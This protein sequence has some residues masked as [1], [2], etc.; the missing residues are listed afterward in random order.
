M[1]YEIFDSVIA[2]KHSGSSSCNQQLDQMVK[3]EIGQHMKYRSLGT[4]VKS[5]LKN[6]ILVE[7]LNCVCEFIFNTQLRLCQYEAFLG[8]PGLGRGRV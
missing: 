3:L 2:T 5:E 1:S 4:N 8:C 6:Q 7:F